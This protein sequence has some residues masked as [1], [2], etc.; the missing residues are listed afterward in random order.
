MFR[1][2][3]AFFFLAVFTGMAPAQSIGSGIGSGVGVDI[4]GQSQIQADLL[5]NVTGVAPGKPFRAGVRLKIAPG[6][7]TYWINSGDSGLPVSVEWNLPEGWKA[8]ALEWP[9]PDKHLEPG[10]MLTYGYDNEVLLMAEITPPANLTPGQEAQLRAKVSWLVCERICVPGSAELDLKIPVVET[11]EPNETALFARYEAKLPKQGPPPFKLRWERHD[12]E[13]YLKLS[14]LPADA[15]I[16]FYPVTDIPRHPE[17]L[18]P[19]VLRIPFPKPPDQ[20][21]VRGLLIVEDPATGSREGWYV[22][23]RSEQ[24]MGKST[25]STPGGIEP[26]ANQGLTIAR[27]LGLGLLG[28]FILNLMPCVL[29]VIAL[30]IFGF[31]GQ[32]G[33]SRQRVFRVGLA[34]V[35]GI[36][37]WFMMLAALVVGAR[38]AGHE[39]AWAFQFQ[40][41][42]FV[43]S[44]A[45]LVFVF[46]LNLLGL[47]E[48]WIPGTG[49]IVSLSSKE[50]Y[51]GA[52]LHGA[53]ATLLAT[54]CTG[55]FLGPVL[56]L[57]FT[58]S[59]GVTFA[60]F[61]AIAT[62]MGLP[63]LVLTAQPAWMRF[64]PKPGPWMVRLKQLMGFLLLG[65]V[66][67]LLG[68]LSSLG[69]KSD[70]ISAIWI[71]LGVGTACWIFGTWI[72]PG[73]RRFQQALALLAMAGAIGLSLFFARPR[74]TAGWENWTPERVAML[75][76]EGKPIFIDFTADWCLNC[77]YN[78][79]FILDAEPVR[80][81]L[82]NFVTLKADWTKGDPV[83]TAELKRLGRSGVP[84][85]AV[86][87]EG[88]GEAEILPEILTQN[89][90]IDALRRARQ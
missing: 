10:D 49:R 40:N 25:S 2:L 77:K 65:T 75:R 23:T 66:V 16:D 68:V 30:K 34:F 51:G 27:A 89:I 14:D 41:P 44:M 47:F 43:F 13:V 80:A 1:T 9:L 5:A 57:A 22:E 45:I 32:A 17:L 55:P 42:V 56:P 19:G 86:Y 82:R 35:A 74:E 78:E 12:T 18:S 3:F 48:I 52:F 83:I 79:R 7:H 37:A 69:E 50:G 58:Q 8:G 81:A 73:A 36:F 60:M 28:G 88:E 20:P 59:A 39:L 33:E 64:L 4:P 46:A 85:Y 21:F 62:G 90:V 11:P 54:P 71:L 67:W 6:W 38:A 87:P 84:V 31:I 26:G 63:Y 70:G 76:K 72:T 15:K 53:F 24:G 61:A 29:P